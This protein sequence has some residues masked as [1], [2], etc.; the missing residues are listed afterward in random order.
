MSFD[1]E[2]QKRSGGHCDLC[3]SDT[4]DISY[5]LPSSPGNKLQHHLLLCS[6]CLS[7]INN[8]AMADGNHWR[9]LNES[10]WSEEPA[11]KVMSWRMLHRLKQFD[12][13]QDLVD[14][15]YLDEETLEWAK[16]AGDDVNPEDLVKHVDCFGAALNNGNN[17]VLIK[18]LDVKGATF[19]AKVG[20]V[21]RK[22]HLLADNAEQIEGR[23]NGSMIVILTKYVKKSAT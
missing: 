23:V 11:V 13:A 14:I 20:T 17:V 16:A 4:A 8:I 15:A 9:C 3:G 6:T 21:V 1:K 22:I 7:Q 5:A 19:N 2:L 18:T 12:W 10:I